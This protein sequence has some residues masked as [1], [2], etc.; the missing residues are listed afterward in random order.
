MRGNRGAPGQQ[1][2][3]SYLGIDVRNEVTSSGVAFGT[4]ADATYIAKV[5]QGAL[6]VTLLMRC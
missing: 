2:G 4:D 5:T 1:T 3:R 6:P